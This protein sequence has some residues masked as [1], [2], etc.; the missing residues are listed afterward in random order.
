MKMKSILKKKTLKQT[1]VL[2]SVASLGITGLAFAQEVKDAKVV[3]EAKEEVGA[4]IGH[5]SGR[6]REGAE[7]GAAAGGAAGA[8]IGGQIE[9]K[10]EILNVGSMAP[11]LEEITWIQGEEVKS[12]NEKGKVYIIECWATWCG[13]CVA[14]IPHMNALHKKYGEKGLVIVG[15]NVMEDDIE[16][17]KKFVKE[18]GDGMSYRVAYAGEKDSSFSKNWLDAAKIQGI[19]EAFVVKD[20]KIIFQGHPRGLNDKTIEQIMASDFNAE[21]F[22]KQQLEEEAKAK[23]FA[24]KIQALFKA[25]DWK[26]IKVL[27]MT[28]EFIKGKVDAAGII[29]QAN[30]RLNDW[31]AQGLLLKEILDGKYGSDVKVTQVLGHGM[32]IVEENDKVKAFAALL[33][34]HYATNKTPEEEDYFGR[35]AYARVLF[36]VGKNDL[37]VKELEGVKIKLSKIE[38]QQGVTEF[39]ANIDESIKGIKEG[40]FPPFKFK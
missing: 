6:G 25:G 14:M 28:D 3:A 39:A 33:E 2:A 4:I 5:Q 21:E 11:A 29:G 32:A 35:I 1:L 40:K 34:P 12:L 8:I 7:I 26:A 20:G 17:A 13:P 31:D 27:A 10:A 38:A 37:A 18:K 19:P 22:A 9:A 23:A 36:M 30:Q 15:M 24:E 16:K